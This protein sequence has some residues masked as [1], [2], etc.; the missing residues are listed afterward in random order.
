M[1]ARSQLEHADGLS[2]EIANC[3]WTRSFANSSKHP[4]CPP[5][6]DDN[7]VAGFKANQ[8]W[9]HE[10]HGDIGFAGGQG[11]L[12]ALSLFLLNV[13]NVFKPF[14]AQHLFG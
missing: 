8:Q 1:L 4:T 7:R 14:G 9:R 5:A 2:F 3:A 12:Y 13:L 6:K 10:V 11:L